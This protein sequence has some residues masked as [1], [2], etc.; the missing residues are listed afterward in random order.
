MSISISEIVQTYLSY[1]VRIQIYNF[2]SFKVLHTFHTYYMF[3]YLTL[4]SKTKFHIALISSYKYMLVSKLPFKP[5][6]LQGRNDIT[7]QTNSS[8]IHMLY[9]PTPCEYTYLNN[10]HKRTVLSASQTKG[11]EMEESV[12]HRKGILLVNTS[13]LYCYFLVNCGTPNQPCL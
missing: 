6:H 13:Q 12:L 7:A 1:R 9:F 8:V 10:S 11:Q 2:F 4:H 5:C 3:H